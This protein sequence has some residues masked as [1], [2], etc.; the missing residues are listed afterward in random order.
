MKGDLVGIPKASAGTANN[1][2]HGA[3]VDDARKKP[4]AGG[5]VTLTS[6]DDAGVDNCGVDDAN[7]DGIKS[8]KPDKSIDHDDLQSNHPATDKPAA[9]VATISTSKQEVK[10]NGIAFK[11]VKDNMSIQM[12]SSQ[13]LFFSGLIAVTHKVGH[14][15]QIMTH[16]NHGVQREEMMANIVNNLLGNP[17]RLPSKEVP[18]SVY[19]SDRMI[20]RLFNKVILRTQTLSIRKDH[21]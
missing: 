13:W 3:D 18:L 1:D 19:S 20:Q 11:D 14:F 5:T 4:M 15:H 12:H 16:V 8:Q 21:E 2:N 9:E 6:I 17:G 10:N 7:V